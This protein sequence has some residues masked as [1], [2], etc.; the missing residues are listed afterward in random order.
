[1]TQK[2]LMITASAV[3]FSTWMKQSEDLKGGGGG[4]VEDVFELRVQE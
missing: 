1:M 3:F 2:K 4:G